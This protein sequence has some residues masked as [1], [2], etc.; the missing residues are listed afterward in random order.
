MS[1]FSFG[2]VLEVISKYSGILEAD[3]F[4]YIV[5]ISSVFAELLKCGFC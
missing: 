4:L 5:F 1:S 3:P 2:V